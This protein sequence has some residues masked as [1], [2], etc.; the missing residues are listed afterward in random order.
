MWCTKYLQW[1]SDVLKED[2]HPWFRTSIFGKKVQL[3]Y[4]CLIG[5]ISLSEWPY[6]SSWFLPFLEQFRDPRVRV[7]S[8]SL[9]L[10]STHQHCPIDEWHCFS[11]NEPSLLHCGTKRPSGGSFK[12]SFFFFWQGVISISAVKCNSTQLI[13]G[14]EIILLS[15]H[16]MK[17]KI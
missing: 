17:S 2:P 15:S 14:G 9:P 7:S 6:H 3:I 5:M 13:K 16:V 4:Q 8:I 11:L 12:A 10:L 1:K